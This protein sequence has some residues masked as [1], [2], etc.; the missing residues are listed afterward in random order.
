MLMKSQALARV[1]YA[2]CEIV[3]LDDGFSALD[4]KT[5]GRIVESLFGPTGHF[6]KM[7]TTVFFITSASRSKAYISYGACISNSIQHNIS[8]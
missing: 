6:K 7:G 2:R 3:V 1:L 5:E 8:I 4:G